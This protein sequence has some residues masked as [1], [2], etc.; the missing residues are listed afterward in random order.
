MNRLKRI[1]VAFL[2]SLGLLGVS[3]CSPK[4]PEEVPEIPIGHTYGPYT[5]SEDSYTKDGK[6]TE[7]HY[8]YFLID[9]LW[10]SLDLIEGYYN[11]YDLSD[12]AGECYWF[13]VEDA[14]PHEVLGFFVDAS[15]DD[16]VDGKIYNDAEVVKQFEGLHDDDTVDPVL[17]TFAVIGMIT[18]IVGVIGGIIFLEYRHHKKKG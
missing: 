6:V 10:M 11:G 14:N 2:L 15:F 1:A 13:F 16:L 12:F 8:E 9:R 3:S 18:V 4:I 7:G 17:T 5:F